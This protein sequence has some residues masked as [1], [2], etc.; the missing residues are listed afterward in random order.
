MLWCNDSTSKRISP[1]ARQQTNN[2]RLTST[3]GGLD[4]VLAGTSYVSHAVHHLL[5]SAPWIAFQTRL[6]LLARLNQR[7]A[8]PKPSPSAPSQSHLLALASLC[9]ETRYTLRLFGLVPLWTWGSSTLKSP[10]SDPVIRALTLLQV[11]VNVLYQLLENGGYLAS[12]GVIPKRLI[13][14]FGGV[15][16]WYLWSIRAW[17]GHIFFQFVLLWRQRVLQRE[18][19]ERSER[20]RALRQEKGE[21]VHLVKEVREEEDVMKAE[22][23]AWRKSLV[24]NVFWSPL[25]LHWCF[26]GGIGFPDQL[27]GLFSF[28]AKV[29]G[30]SDSWVATG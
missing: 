29:W 10:P 8:P 15:N 5:A 25:C 30:F 7:P 6:S 3:A 21:D 17:F 12:R 16:K 2:R 23:R 9:S 19:A 22:N 4:A 26:E 28:L 18:R 1:T 14:R 11:L 27:T 24:N 20:E 13:D